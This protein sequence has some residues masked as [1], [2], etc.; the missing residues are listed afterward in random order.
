[1]DMFALIIQR[2]INLSDIQINRLSKPGG[3]TFQITDSFLPQ[4]SKLRILLLLFV[5]FRGDI[6]F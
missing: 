6:K 2:E 5:V 1:M 3:L 4:L